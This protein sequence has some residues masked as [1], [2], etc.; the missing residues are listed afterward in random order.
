MNP[1][2]TALVSLCLPFL[3]L[4]GAAGA[5]LSKD[6]KNLEMEI[7]RL[8]RTAAEAG[9]VQAVHARMQ[10]DFRVPPAQVR[11]LRE[12][13]FGYGEIVVL[14]SL[15]K[16]LPGGITDGNIDRVRSLRQGPPPL[17]WGQVAKELGAKLG[18][19]VSQ[20]KKVRNETHRLMKQEQA[21]SASSP[22]EQKVAPSPHAGPRT[23]F[24]GEGR[25]LPRGRA[26]D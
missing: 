15:A 24:S 2:S 23:D 22:S 11:S 25:S 19:V 13:G 18:G 5:S 20:V 21:T 17:G 10:R 9:G 4:S 14:L 26:A 7:V 6:E 16:N 3:L 1:L 12:Q 8:D